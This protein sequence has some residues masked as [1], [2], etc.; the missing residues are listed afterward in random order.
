MTIVID[1]DNIQTVKPKELI[2]FGLD[3][4]VVWNVDRDKEISSY[5]FI[6]AALTNGYNKEIVLT[7]KEY[8][9]EKMILDSLTKYRYRVSDKLSKTV[10]LYLSTSLLSS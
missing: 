2:K 3:P 5:I 4:A 10:K 7:L 6:V 1:K 9:G 8:F